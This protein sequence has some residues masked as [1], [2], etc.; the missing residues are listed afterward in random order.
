M[1]KY[2]LLLPSV[3]LAGA[4]VACNDLDTAPMS[5][6][7]T[8]DQREDV[9]AGDPEK[10]EAMSAGVY[11]NFNTWQNAISSSQY[12]N[13]AY[14]DFGLAA[15]FLQ[16]DSR[17]A[18]MLTVDADYYGW[19]AS[20]VEYLDNTASGSY[21]ATRWNLSYNAINS[22]NQ[23][24][25]TVSPDTEDP[26]LKY[27][28]AQ[29][30]GNRAY[31]YWLLA[32]EYQFNYAQGYQ[33]YP[34]VPIITDENSEEAALNGAP[35]AT[36]ANVYAQILSDLNTAIELVDGNPVATRPDK[37]YID[38]NVLLALRARTYLCM[39]DYTNAAA[40]AQAVISSG[41]FTPLSAQE[42]LLPGFNELTAKNWI[43]GINMDA[44]DVAGLYTFFG[45]MGSY[46]Y[47]YAYVG[48]WKLI[49]SVLWAQIPVGDVRKLWWIA[50]DTR[51]SNAMYY[52]DA[53]ENAVE[54]LETVEAPDYA[55]VKYAPYQNVLRQSDNQ[56]DV[57]II[58]IEEMYLILAEAQ[59]LGGNLS[60]GIQTL[61][62]FVNNYRM[63]GA[64]YTCRASNSE[65]FIDAI[66]LQRRVELWGEGI[67][68]FDVL[69]LGKPI[70]R[71]SNGASNWLDPDNLMDAYAY[72]IPAGSPVLIYQIPESVIQNN[73]QITQADQNPT[74]TASL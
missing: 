67:N 61:E 4:F 40:D 57:P 72:Y 62:E 59:G 5:S 19:F 13:S 65:E 34:C 27:Y 16:W 69:R 73:P 43:W 74:G 23:V 55:V 56:G 64:T 21:N 52:T 36:V 17:T 22:A 37:R 33:D 38:K 35:R 18:D 41:A 68:Y 7:I 58:R 47:G 48:M 6:T 51:E 63:D 44:E 42:A 3:L 71:Q 28:R 70:D 50:P 31:Q 2:K 45:M 66:W 9:I 54:Y 39:G 15:L 25:G 11:A 49:D 26:Q 14:A 10:L 46:T 53:S 8:A 20:C 24:L 30:L 60:Q 12:G 1:N 32:Q 29:A